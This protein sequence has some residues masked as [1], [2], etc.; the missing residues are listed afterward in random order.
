M[1]YW[2]RVAP[3]TLTGP[4][5]AFLKNIRRIFGRIADNQLPGHLPLFF[6]GTRK[7]IS[8]GRIGK[9]KVVLLTAA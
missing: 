2:A 8:H 3:G 5:G 7:I 9:T 4:L 1:S 6:T